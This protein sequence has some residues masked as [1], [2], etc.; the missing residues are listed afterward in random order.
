M[1][2]NWLH[3]FSLAF[4]C[5]GTFSDHQDPDLDL[6]L[7]DGPIDACD[8]ASVAP[9][10]ECG[11][12]VTA[13]KSKPL[14]GRAFADEK[15]SRA[16]LKKRKLDEALG[17]RQ[18]GSRKVIVER[19]EATK[20]SDKIIISCLND[21]RDEFKAANKI[22]A[23]AN[24][25]REVANKQRQANLQMG[26]RREKIS[27]LQDEIKLLNDIGSV[28]EAAARKQDLLD[29]LRSPVEPP[30]VEVTEQILPGADQGPHANVS[31][32]Q[33]TN[34]VNVQATPSYCAGPGLTECI[35]CEGGAGSA[36][37][38]LDLEI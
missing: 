19:D 27:Q 14:T 4:A 28:E 20:E 9:S 30:R 2:Q 15:L 11:Q 36:A 37:E 29:L 1:P 22:R 24:R 10:S 5:F 12:G 13:K 35:G 3:T 17:G 26:F 25:Q 18:M 7:S 16:E 33:S 32:D 34:I 31:G 23:E 38:P 8:S 21:M 6:K